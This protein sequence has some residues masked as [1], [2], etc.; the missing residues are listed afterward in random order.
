MIL[1][2]WVYG[3]LCEVCHH[4][5][6]ALYALGRYLSSWWP[7]LAYLANSSCWLLVPS[8][9]LLPPFTPARIAPRSEGIFELAIARWI[10][11]I[12]G[13]HQ[14]QARAQKQS[15]QRAGVGI[16]RSCDS[17]LDLGSDL[18]SPKFALNPWF[19]QWY[20]SFVRVLGGFLTSHL[21]RG[22]V[23]WPC[24]DVGVRGAAIRWLVLRGLRG[25]CQRTSPNFALWA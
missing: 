24:G 18:G 11:L 21:G 4:S 14:L 16:L 6:C 20:Q 13:Y 1:W 17:A 19:S 15:R 3:P 12:S 2:F 7:S 9:G 25:G 10:R 5:W 8:V 23:W 22:Q